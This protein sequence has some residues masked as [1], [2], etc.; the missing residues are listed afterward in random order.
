MTGHFTV[1]PLGNLLNSH[2]PRATS[3]YYFAMTQVVGASRLFFK[4][5][6][7]SLRGSRQIL[8]LLG[9]DIFQVTDQELHKFNVLAISL[10]LCHPC[11]IAS[12]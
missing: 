3:V 9:E 2:Y 7:N 11:V 8:R 10:L 4:V 6:G 5:Y 1:N 12:F